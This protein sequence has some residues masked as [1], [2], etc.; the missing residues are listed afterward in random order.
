MFSEQYTMIFDAYVS[1][2][3]DTH[4]LQYL[5]A[6]IIYVPFV[7]VQALVQ[8]RDNTPNRPDTSTC[9]DTTAVEHGSDGE[10]GSRLDE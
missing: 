2:C 10:G 8:V 1:L 6:S 9:T 5:I 3:S 7:L 4:T